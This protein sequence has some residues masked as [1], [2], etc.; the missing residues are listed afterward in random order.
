[1]TPESSFGWI[2]QRFW[3]FSLQ[4]TLIAGPPL[5]SGVV[6][7]GR[8]LTL[9]RVSVHPNDG[10]KRQLQQGIGY[11]SRQGILVEIQHL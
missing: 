10:E 5:Q 11:H 4:T 3:Y 9:K 6:T 8:I 7:N 2:L 1:M